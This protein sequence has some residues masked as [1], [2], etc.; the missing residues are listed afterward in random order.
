MGFK[1]FKS[2]GSQ[3]LQNAGSK[4]A[5]LAV[6]T[7]VPIIVT[8]TSDQLATLTSSTQAQIAALTSDQ[9]VALIAP[10]LVV[11][12]ILSTTYYIYCHRYDSFGNIYFGGEG[13]MGIYKNNV[14]TTVVGNGTMGFSGDG[15][16]DTSALVGSVVGIDFDAIGNIYFADFTNH[17]IRKINISTGIITTIAGTGGQAGKSYIRPIN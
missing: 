6:S 7:V 9:I 17:V 8:L 12:K 1:S 2:L 15:G 13:I 5:A 14:I 16:L 3:N 11:N 4:I 10:G